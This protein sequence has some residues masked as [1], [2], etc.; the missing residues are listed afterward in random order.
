MKSTGNTNILIIDLG[1]ANKYDLVLSNGDYVG[2]IIAPG[3]ITSSIAL[4]LNTGKLPLIKFNKLSR[5]SPLIGKNTFEAIQSGLVNYMKL[6]TE[7]IVDGVKRKYPGKL[8]IYIT[9]GSAG[10]IKSK[11]NFD[12]KYTENSVLH[13]LN[14]V[15]NFQK[16]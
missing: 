9:G 16:A 12:Y 1:T 4:N 3:L 15:I 6:A 14:Y 7:G 13:G 11:L 10:L 5:N 8:N 2:G